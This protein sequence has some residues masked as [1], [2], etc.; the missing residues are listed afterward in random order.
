MLPLA[1][2]WENIVLITYF[3]PQLSELIHNSEGK[4][5]IPQCS[6]EVWFREII[7]LVSALTPWHA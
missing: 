2:S 6:V 5:D 1:A 7:D 3:Q 4:E